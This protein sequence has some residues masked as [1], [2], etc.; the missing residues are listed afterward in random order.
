[1]IMR[2]LN[3]F[4]I[5]ALI[6]SVA[7]VAMAQDKKEEKAPTKE[8]YI[9]NLDSA[10]AKKQIEAMKFIQKNKV[11]EA[12]DKVGKLLESASSSDIRG[13]AASTLSFLEDKEKANPFL[14][15]AIKGD[16][17]GYVRYMA[18]LAVIR[19]GDDKALEALEYAHKNDQDP[20]VKDVVRRLLVKFGKIKE[21]GKKVT[22]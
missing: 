14:T 2:K 3:L 6:L 4:L 11:K 1:M 17:S 5:A 10:D 8:E 18:V 16:T 7:S 13:E 12:L 19:L 9:K 21:E 15:K 20:D 22:Q